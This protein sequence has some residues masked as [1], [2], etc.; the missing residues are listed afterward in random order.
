MEVMGVALP[1]VFTGIAQLCIVQ[2]GIHMKERFETLC[3]RAVW[4]ILHVQLLLLPSL[5]CLLSTQILSASHVGLKAGKTSPAGWRWTHQAAS[6]RRR[7]MLHAPLP[8]LSG[9]PSAGQK[10]DC[11]RRVSFSSVALFYALPFQQF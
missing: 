11:G 1:F 2:S 3:L 5:S 7:A 8:E 4:A 6:A 10:E 9:C